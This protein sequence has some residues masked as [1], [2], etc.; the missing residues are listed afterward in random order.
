MMIWTLPIMLS[1]TIVLDTPSTTIQQLR[2]SELSERLA[3]TEA[4][5]LQLELQIAKA[6]HAI[7]GLQDK[8]AEPSEVASELS[9]YELVGIV[10]TADKTHVVLRYGDE[11]IRLLSGVAGPMELTAEV[12]PGRVRLKRFGH[13]RDLPLTER[14]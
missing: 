1:G 7:D 2:A 8:P 11:L 13:F 3:Q 14:W 4:K 5:R 12:G 10:S 9:Q 6:R